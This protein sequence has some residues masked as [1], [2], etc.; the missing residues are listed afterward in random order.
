MEGASC[1][2]VLERATGAHCFE[3]NMEVLDPNSPL[4]NPDAVA[5]EI[6]WSPETVKRLTARAD[7]NFPQICEDENSY[8]DWY[9]MSHFWTAKIFLETCATHG[10]GIR[11]SW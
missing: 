8:P 3:Q 9:E 5:S 11:I 10:L 1:G 2:L 6:E 7:W 4:F